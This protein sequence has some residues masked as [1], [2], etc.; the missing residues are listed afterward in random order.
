MPSPIR[1]SAVVFTPALR[2]SAGGE[3][4]RALAAA[5]DRPVEVGIEQVRVGQANAEAAQLAEARGTAADRSADHIAERLALVAGV[6]PDQVLSTA[7]AD[8]ARP[9]RESARCR[10]RRLSVARGAGRR[11]RGRLDRSPVPPAA[12]DFPVIASVANPLAPEAE[13]A[14]ATVL[15]ASRRVEAPITVSGLGAEAVAE[16]LREAGADIRIGGSPRGPVRFEWEARG[17]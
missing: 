11:E 1:V 6:A 2:P 13:R 3:A 10:A 8:R 5:I 4:T 12:A 17:E 9:G 14:L 15:W 7:S 16:R